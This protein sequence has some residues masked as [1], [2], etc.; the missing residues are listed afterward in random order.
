MKQASSFDLAP[1]LP[2]PSLSS[3]PGDAYLDLHVRHEHGEAGQVRARAA[4]VR[5]VG[6]QE[7]TVLRRPESRHGALGV[8]P[9][10]AVGIEVLLRVL[11]VR[12]G[13]S[14]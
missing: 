9:E 2:S 10:R 12:E 13:G 8:A 7:A 4:G 6:G 14:G 3:P 1:L 11:E 5:A